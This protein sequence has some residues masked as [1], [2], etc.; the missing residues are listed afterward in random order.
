VRWQAKLLAVRSPFE[1]ILSS[2]ADRFEEYEDWGRF[3]V[4]KRL[5]AGE[6]YQ[7]IEDSSRSEVEWKCVGGMLISGR[8]IILRLAEGYLL[9]RAGVCFCRCTN[10]L[11][12][13]MEGL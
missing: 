11:L 12:F 9:S 13:F 3:A 2:Q 8:L 1:P 4:K 5:I 10:Y 6:N 7:E